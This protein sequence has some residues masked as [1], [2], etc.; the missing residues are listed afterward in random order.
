MEIIESGIFDEEPNECDCCEDEW[1]AV[2]WIKLRLFKGKRFIIKL[3][4]CNRC[5]YKLRQHI[6]AQEL[7]IPW[8]M[9][10]IWIIVAG[11]V[12]YASYHL[13]KTGIQLAQLS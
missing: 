9:K 13:I 2:N 11:I 5:L 8:E 3:M 4:L 10:A 12:T 6:S 1:N 7:K